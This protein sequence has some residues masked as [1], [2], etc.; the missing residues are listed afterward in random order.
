MLAIVSAVFLGRKMFAR[1]ESF[2]SVTKAIMEGK[3]DKRVG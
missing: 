1:I 3:L 2:T